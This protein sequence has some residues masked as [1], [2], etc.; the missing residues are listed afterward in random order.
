MS[1]EYERQKAQSE[2]A[3][4]GL[5]SHVKSLEHGWIQALLRRVLRIALA[6]LVVLA[7]ILLAGRVLLTQPLFG[8]VTRQVGAQADPER[9]RAEVELLT[10]EFFARNPRHPETL[11]AAADHIH[12]V[13]ESLGLEVHEQS[14]LVG[15]VP[16][17]N[18]I[19]SFGPQTGPVVIVGA[20]YDVFGDLPGADDNASGT[21][22]LLELA[23][24]LSHR[25][26]D[27]AV[28]LV[29]YSTEE[30]PYFGSKMMGSFTH[31]ASLAESGRSVRAMLCLE[32]IGYFS[33]H[34]RAP[35]ALMRAFYPSRGDFALIAGRWEDR[36]L[37]RAVKQGFRAASE[38]PVCSYCGPTGLGTDLS[39]H[40]N[41]WARGYSAVMIT[42][43][44]FIRNTRYHTAQDTADTLDYTRM[45][46]VVDGVAG[47]VALLAQTPGGS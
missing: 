46:G 12:E 23:R 10:Q 37:I 20:H 42:D 24:L 35:I 27:G 11:D 29:A 21:A 33:E 4:P 6:V 34:Q 7:A 2:G 22:G 38:L 16:C 39:D 43:T 3:E 26:I 28:E 32:M 45:A 9:L 44:A 13:F 41:Y 14:Y 1:E 15:G 36:P 31:A 19:V 8:G 47:A 40:R 17:R 18:V 25:T 30:P 5:S